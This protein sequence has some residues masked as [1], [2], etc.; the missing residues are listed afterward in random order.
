MS[1][2]DRV[3]KLITGGN[4]GIGKTAMLHKYVYGEFNKNTTVTI[5]L[6]FFIKNVSYSSTNF[7]L[8]MW[9]LGGE[10]RF[11]FLHEKFIKGAHVGLLL[12]DLTRIVSLENIP[13]WARMFRSQDNALPLVLVG[14]KHDLIEIK[15]YPEVQESLISEIAEKCNIK[16]EYCL[17]ISSKT[18]FNVDKV[19]K[20]ASELALEHLLKKKE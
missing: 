17:K 12:F 19:F 9:D 3:F 4:G 5:S 2:T 6:D 18:G 11:R 8:Q 10:E 1:S 13:Y 15:R 16:K 20:L 7:T 14:T